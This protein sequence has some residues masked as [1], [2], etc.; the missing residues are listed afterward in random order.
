MEPVMSS[1]HSYS[2][3]SWVLLP[4]PRLLWWTGLVCVPLLTVAVA[5][6]GSVAGLAALIG[7]MLFLLVLIADGMGCASLGREI[8]LGCKD[9]VIL[10]RNQHGRIELSLHRAPSVDLRAF[11]GL[12][13]WLGCHEP[14]ARA[15]A[16][17][18]TKGGSA[19][20]DVATLCWSLRPRRRG[21]WQAREV[22]LA[23]AS[24]WSLWTLQRHYR[25]E[26]TVRVLPDIRTVYKECLL[27]QRRTVVGQARMRLLGR[28]REYEKLREYQPGDSF[29]DIHW[30]ATAK[31]QRLI[32]KEYQMERRQAV[33][34]VVDASRLS[35]RPAEGGGTPESIL[36]RFIQAA[37]GL[38]LTSDRVQD[39]CGLV[40]FADRI[41]AFLPA[42]HGRD[43]VQRC[44]ELL[45]AVEQSE[46]SPDFAEIGNELR[47][48]I[49]Q[50]ALLVFLTNLD[51][52]VLAADF[53]RQARLLS[54]QH[55]VMVD[56]YRPAG[57][58]PLLT[59]KVAES[60]AVYHALA[61]HLRWRQLRALMLTL[62]RDGVRL[63]LLAPGPI[64]GQLSRQYLAVKQR[65]LV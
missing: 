8:T 38:L 60:A 45:G 35:G 50:R 29:E 40:V 27:M 4:S 59:T 18:A 61:G 51:D 5:T 7:L 24:P 3:A 31:H 42:K 44:R 10:S 32:T 36:E 55:L 1:E 41:R 26:L 46:D 54:Q 20:G 65:Q 2:S 52:P 25:P 33:Y 22:V 57:A 37:L 11:L 30:K 34:V 53:T 64:A 15:A 13:P 39:D 63:A 58:A 12:A 56:M 62:R 49:R 16:A 17:A 47:T 28:G 6:A 43:H 21:S 48:R 14:W 9:D 23:M 19:A